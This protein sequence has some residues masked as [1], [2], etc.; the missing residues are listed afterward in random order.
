MKRFTE[1]EYMQIMAYEAKI[2]SKYGPVSLLQFSKFIETFYVD[3]QCLNFD[4]LV[5]ICKLLTNSP[6]NKISKIC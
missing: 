2:G 3:N 1:A 4:E 5:T 6:T